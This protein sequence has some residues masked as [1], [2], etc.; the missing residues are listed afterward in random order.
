MP[1]HETPHPAPAGATPAR[2]RGS[3]PRASAKKETAFAV[4]FCISSVVRAVPPLQLLLQLEFQLLVFLHQRVVVGALH[5]V[6][7]E[8]KRG[9][10]ELLLRVLRQQGAVLPAQTGDLDHHQPAVLLGQLKQLQLLGDLQLQIAALIDDLQQTALLRLGGHDDA[11][12]GKQPLQIA[13][14][15]LLPGN[16][17]LADAGEHGVGQV[18]AHI[19]LTAGLR[20]FHGHTS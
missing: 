20:V 1:E 6:L 15:D 7:H 2:R 8:R 14:G 4:S 3:A 16:G 17:A 9:L 5:V 19:D 10:V 18:Q 11:V 12:L 13:G